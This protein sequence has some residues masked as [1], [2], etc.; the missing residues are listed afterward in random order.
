[1]ARAD[2]ARG[3]PGAHARVLKAGE[4][5]SL[6]QSTQERAALAVAEREQ[7]AAEVAAEPTRRSERDER[8][9][10]ERDD[11]R[12]PV[13]KAEPLLPERTRDEGDEDRERPEDERDGRSRRQANGIDERD[14]VQP[15]ADE[16]GTDQEPHVVAVDAQALLA[17]VRERGEEERR[18]P[19]AKRRVRERLETVR[20]RVLG[21]GEVEAPEDDR[22]QQ[23]RVRGDPV[24]QA[25]EHEGRC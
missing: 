11:G 13:A 14:L 18:R 16:R 21:G 9:A 23:E 10:R 12:E 3:V 6:L 25:D 17:R 2:V 15:D 22:R 24:A 5:R 8:H 4:V 19:E 7:H 1:M 20:E